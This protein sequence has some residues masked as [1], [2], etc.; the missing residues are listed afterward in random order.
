VVEHLLGICKALGLIPSTAKKELKTIY[1][2]YI[3]IFGNCMIGPL[4]SPN[5]A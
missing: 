1:E 5:K 2:K 4:P 3:C